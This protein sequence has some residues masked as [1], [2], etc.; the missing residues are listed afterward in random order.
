MAYDIKLTV[1]LREG[2][3][4]A[5]TVGERTYPSKT[6]AEDK[7]FV[8][9]S[10]VAVLWDSDA[11]GAV[12]DFD[13]LVLTSDSDV[14]LELTCN[15]GDGN[16]ELSGLML[17]ANVPLLL[18]SNVSRYNYGG[19]VFDGT[20]DVIDRIRAKESAGIA[21]NIRLRLYT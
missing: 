9:T 10:A 8:L 4:D 15:D 13:L 6:L 5:V 21:A 19:D 14:E 2:T 17:A 18:G 1:T 20:L 12:A 3:D 11:D 7:R 16:E